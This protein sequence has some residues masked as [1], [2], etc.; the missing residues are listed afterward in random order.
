LEVHVFDASGDWYGHSV[1]VEFVARLRDTMK[2]SGPGELVAQLQSDAMN[3]RAALTA[4]VRAV[5]VN[6]SGTNTSYLL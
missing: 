6:D 4:H 3:A 5:N 1:R 2:F